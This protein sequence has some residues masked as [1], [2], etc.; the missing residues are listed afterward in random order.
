M[1]KTIFPEIRLNDRKG[2]LMIM[3]PNVKGIIVP[4]QD[5]ILKSTGKPNS[6][7]YKIKNVGGLHNY[8]DFKG[9]II[10]SLIMRDDLISLMLPSDYAEIING[11]EPNCYTTIDG[12]TYENQEKR[13]LKELERISNETLELVRLCPGKIP[14]G[15]VK[16]SSSIQIKYHFSFL[17]NVGIKIFIFH[18]GDF[19]R[20]GDQ[21]MIK[22]AKQYCSLIKKADNI[23][24]LHGMGSQNKIIEFSFA[25]IYCTY[26]HMITARTGQY[27]S[28]TKKKKYSIGNVEDIASLNLNQMF[29]NLKITQFQTKLFEGGRFLWEEVMQEQ[30]LVL[31]K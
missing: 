24:I 28:G 8:L 7:F 18:T 26:S 16:G 2:L 10:L 9:L 19:F 23:L 25:D 17:K 13:S 15:H 22:K 12:S 31:L 21:N 11:A 29:K 27:Y 30:E 6:L 20:N 5:L 4:I 1:V 14:I 3:N